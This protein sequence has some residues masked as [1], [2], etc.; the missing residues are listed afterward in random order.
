VGYYPRSDHAPANAKF[1]DEPETLARAGLA[2]PLPVWPETLAPLIKQVI[3]YLRAAPALLG[4]GASLVYL[5]GLRALRRPDSLAR[6][7]F[8]RMMSR[9]VCPAANLQVRVVGGEKL[10][11]ARPCVYVVNHQS[12][13]D[14]VIL[15]RIFPEDTVVMARQRRDLPV[16]RWLFEGTGNIAVE[17]DVPVRAVAALR[18]AERVIR[19]RGESVWIFPEGTRG[20]VAGRLQPFKRGAFRLALSAGVPVVPIVVSPLKPR[21][22]IPGH[23]LLPNRVEVHVLDPVSTAGLP[24]DQEPALRGRVHALMADTLRRLPAGA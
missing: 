12:H 6:R 22:D 14:Y 17:R 23:R 16:I 15:G 9:L 21:T 11:R 18:Q 1:R 4:F 20:K 5:M 10:T 19:E 7:D 2:A 13:L 3:F 24:P 8:A